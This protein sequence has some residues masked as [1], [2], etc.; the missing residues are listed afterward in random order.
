VVVVVTRSEAGPD[1]CP[2]SELSDGAAGAG[3]ATRNAGLIR[4][5]STAEGGVTR[6]SLAAGFAPEPTPTTNDQGG[7]RVLGELVSHVIGVDTHKDTHTA[8]VVASVSGAVEATATEPA[9]T[10]GYE[11]L[12][13]LA[14]AYTTAGERA[15]A[16]EGTGSYGAGLAMFLAAA[17]EWVIEVDRPGR[18]PRRNGSKS[19]LIDAQRAAREALGKQKWALPR[20]RGDREALR[21]LVTTRD[22]A[23][24]DRT[25]A[26]NQLKAIVVTAPEQLR[27][28]LRGH[29]GTAQLVTACTRLRELDHHD[30]ERR[31]TTIALRRLA[32]RIRA[33]SEEITDYDQR[34]AVLA[35]QTCPQ[36]LTE[37]GIGPLTAARAYISWSHH[38]RCRSEAAYANLAGAAPIEASSGKTIRHRLN[39][40]GDR[41]LNRAL[42]TIAIVRARSDPRTQAYITRRLADGKTEREARRCLKRYIARHLFK[43]LEAGAPQQPDQT[44]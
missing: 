17:G 24:V 35:N 16:V 30:S 19:D 15:W 31:A 1:G 43:L 18:T 7:Y 27:D 33:L 25:A 42:H 14:D 21:V 11:A 39:R 9:V 13:E 3:P 8:A 6:H 36:L 38:G 28:R 12:V 32:A 41:Q 40:G 5:L 26:I 34:I 37:H 10:A 2:S 23:V 4:S 22:S 44:P 20:A 29:R